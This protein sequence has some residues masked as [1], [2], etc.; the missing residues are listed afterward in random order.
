[1]D[2]RSLKDNW[3]GKNVK[4]FCPPNRI[5]FFWFSLFYLVKLGQKLEPFKHFQTFPNILGGP[6]RR[7]GPGDFWKPQ[8]VWKVWK[9][10]KVWI[11]IQTFPN[12]SKHFQT[13]WRVWKCLEM[14]GNVWECLEMSEKVWIQIQTF[15]AIQTFQTFWGFPKSPGPIFNHFQ[16]CWHVWKCLEMFG[17][18]WKV[19]KVW[20][21]IQK[22][23][24]ISKHF[25][26]FWGAPGGGVAWEIFGNPKRFERFERFES[27]F[28]PFQTLPKIWKRVWKC[29]EMSVKVWIRIQTFQTFQT[30]WGFPKS[31]GPIFKHFQTRWRVWKCLEMFVNVWK[32]WKVW[33]RI[34]TFQTFPNISKHSGGPPAAGWPG[35]FLETPKGLKDLKGL[36]VWK[37]WIRIQTFQ[38]FQSFPKSPG[39]IFKHF[40]TR[41]RVWKCLEMFERFERFESG[42]KPFKPFQ[43]FPNISKHFQTFPNILGGPRRRGGPE[44]S[45]KPQN[46]WKVW[47]R[48]QTFSN[49][50]KHFQT[51]WR[52]W[53]CLE[54]FGNVWKCLE[55]LEKVWI[56]IQTFQTFQTFWGFRKSPRPIFK[57]FQTRWRVWKCLE[58]FGN[59]WKV[60]IRIQTFQTFPNISKHFQTFWGA[61]GGGVAREIFGNPKMFES[62]KGLKGLNLD[63]NL[64]KNFQTFPNT[65]TC[66]KMFGNVWKCL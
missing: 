20:I 7:G 57:H 45:W 1:M 33:F 55:M 50:S 22:F 63:S 31:P 23:P 62:L 6:R 11:R 27:G 39:Q 18:V 42:F 54:M 32:V 48:I 66:L 34:Q 9:V 53:K 4:H 17:K 44:D 65:L 41:W 10:W 13:R 12:I 35:R 46:V 3:G 5:Y 37:G 29:L 51:R 16:T 21:R 24:N 36:N 47:I 56:W 61:P 30:F 38:T 43:A 59:V 14:F 40:Q 15:Q 2:L 52:V 60:W 25:Q 49:I 8:N 26:T 64:F 58:M 19:W 28:K